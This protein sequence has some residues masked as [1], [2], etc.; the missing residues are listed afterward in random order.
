MTRAAIL[1]PL[2]LLGLAQWVAC[3]HEPAPD[4]SGADGRSQARLDAAVAA[5]DQPE[6]DFGTVRQGQSV[7]HAFGLHNTGTE[8]LTIDRVRAGCSCIVAQVSQREIPPGGEAEIVV[9]LKTRGRKGDQT[10]G[11]RVFTNAPQQ[12]E[13]DLTL[14]GKVEI[15]AGF[16]TERLYLREVLKGTSRTELVELE[17]SRLA[18]L[19]PSAPV[20]NAPG[21]LSGDWI[22]QDGRRKLKVTF[23][24]GQQEGRFSGRLTAQ[25]GLAEPAQ[26]GLTVTAM[27]TGDLVADRG[28]VTFGPYRKEHTPAFEVTVRSMSHRPFKIE[29]V[30]DPGGLVS[31]EAQLVEAGWRIALR[32]TKASQEPRGRI[33]IKT[34]RA[35]QRFIELSYLV[36]DGHRVRPAKARV[37]LKE[38]EP[39]SRPSLRLD[40]PLVP[41]SAKTGVRL[42][43]VA[44]ANPVRVKKARQDE[45]LPHPPPGA[46]SIQPTP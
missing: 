21:R 5:C 17:G 11:V 44:P 18:E 40:R 27:V 36:R 46:Q 24:A 14:R 35:D 4:A 3:R 26:L 41:G 39:S 29:A 12:P 8:A 19:K 16:A 1:I 31:G 30:E 20:T 37:R 6:F 13:L 33:R 28:L 34:D 38:L 23:I 2:G 42:R 32:L 45:P 22:E 7:R 9:R 15:L 25:T 43:R 10:L